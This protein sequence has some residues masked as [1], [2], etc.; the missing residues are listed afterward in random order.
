MELFRFWPEEVIL[1]TTPGLVTNF[2]LRYIL[3]T[4]NEVPQKI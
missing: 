3:L 2:G 1:P 4:Q